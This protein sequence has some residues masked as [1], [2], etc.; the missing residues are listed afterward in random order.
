MV[1]YARG[2][3]LG[4]IVAAYIRS[5]LKRRDCLRIPPSPEVGGGANYHIHPCGMYNFWGAFFGQKY[6]LECCFGV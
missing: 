2:V 6:I 5:A 1:I 3:S 4:N